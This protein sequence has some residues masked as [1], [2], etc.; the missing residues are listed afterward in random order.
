MPLPLNK[1]L[2]KNLLISILAGV[3][4][5][6]GA[7]WSRINDPGDKKVVLKEEAT[8]KNE[9]R[10][11]EEQLN[12]LDSEAVGESVAFNTTE[13][14]ETTEKG[15]L[16]NNQLALSNLSEEEIAMLR[17]INTPSP[18]TLSYDELADKDALYTEGTHR[19]S[20]K[21]IKSQVTTN[22]ATLL[23]YGLDITKII[24]GYPFYTKLSP[25]EITFNIYSKKTGDISELEAVRLS[26]EALIKRLL[27]ATVPKDLLDLHV[28]VINSADR[29]S[30]LIKNMEKVGTDQL[31]A[32]NSA[33]HYIEEG[34]FFL[35]S[36]GEVN[37]FLKEKNITLGDENMLKLS[38]DLI[39]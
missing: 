17:A 14:Q 3:S 32:L 23:T 36:L 9:G 21:D 38:I 1:L 5:V 26:Y 34:Y 30:Q 12:S 25:T 16:T 33:R 8:I 24:V 29:S 22:R 37:L 10:T 27:S 4:I 39:R 19:Y 2:T 35:R 15:T 28:K 6:G 18:S 11:L 20:T 13:N 31:L 7:F